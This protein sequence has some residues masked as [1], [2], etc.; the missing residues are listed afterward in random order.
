MAPKPKGMVDIGITNMQELTKKL[1][2]IHDGGAQAI[3]R[4]VKDFKKRAPSWISR[5]VR[6]YYGIP[7]K[8][9]SPKTK[10]DVENKVRKAGR[11]SGAGETIDTLAIVY[12][13]QVLTPARFTMNP[14]EPKEVYTIKATIKKGS[15]KRIGGKKKLTKAQKKNIG[16][17]FTHQGVRH[18]RELPIILR[19]TGN[20]KESGIN[21]IP[22]R[23][24][25]DQKTWKPI[26]TLSM[27]QMVMN[28]MV[29]RGISKEL[30][31]N[32]TKRMEHHIKTCI[33]KYAK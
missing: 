22:M 14:K 3:E 10:K 7:A 19:H 9:I 6:E 26:K 25:P 5:A 1:N 21:Y 13:G 33:N 23:L 11:I 24:M 28:N 2:G 16:R 29:Q 15:R 20:K 31:D 17:N 30:Q 4:T 8:E 18:R 27:P 12:R 32:M